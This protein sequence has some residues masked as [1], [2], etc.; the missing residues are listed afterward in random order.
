MSA[1]PPKAD[2]DTDNQETTRRKIEP[3]C[4]AEICGGR[5]GFSE[6]KQP[7]GIAVIDHVAMG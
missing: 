2:I 1:L 7:L 3:T 4:N 5:R 6:T